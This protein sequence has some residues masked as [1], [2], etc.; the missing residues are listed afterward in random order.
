MRPRL[1][2]LNALK[3]FEAA[4]RHES[5]TRAAEELCVTQGAVSHQVKALEAELAVKL[6]NRERQRLIITE[7]GKDY[8]TVVRDALDRI[9]VG[10]ERLLQR[11]NAGVLTV[12]TS[13]DFAAKWLVHRLG[14][15]ADAHPGIDLRVS[16]T[17]HHVDFAREEVDLAVRHGEGSW[18]GLDTVRLSAEQLFAVCSPKLISGRR[19]LNK[20]ADILN[21]PLLHL[22]SRADWT[23]WLQAAGL[24]GAD[25]MHGPV[26][27]R[28]SMVIDA[29]INGQGIAL[30]RTT[31]AAWDIIN[32]RLVRPFSESLRLSKTYWIVCPK[33]TATVPKIVTFRDWLLAEASSDLRRLKKLG[34]S[35][36]PMKEKGD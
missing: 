26:L 27:N 32:G 4:A 11:Q 6:F 29:A 9:A 15:F 28:A 23:N 10:T 31:L 35:L 36:R 30:A 21:F 25:V 2:P 17:L 14:H 7:A 34:W 24:D 22:D 8:L 12:S 16:A 5:F 18:P 3:A 33:A 19:R 13:P 20:P 1:P